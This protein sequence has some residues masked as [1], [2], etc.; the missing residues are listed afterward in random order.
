MPTTAALIA[1]RARA[2]RGIRAAR[3]RWEGQGKG[4]EG[5]RAPEGELYSP[6][7]ASVASI[8]IH[9]GRMNYKQERGRE[10]VDDV[11]CPKTI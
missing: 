2:G 11:I 3:G 7:A 8:G 10:K 1:T 9:G 6:E 5:D 4:G